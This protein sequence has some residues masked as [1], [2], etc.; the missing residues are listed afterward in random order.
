MLLQVHDG[1]A[2]DFAYPP[3]QVR[4]ARR[5]DVTLVLPDAL[6]DAVV[7]VGTGVRAWQAHEPGIL[8]DAKRDA[9]LLPELLELCHDAVGDVR[10][11][12]CIEAVH[13]AA[14]QIDLVLDAEVDE[15]GVHQNAVRRAQRGVVLEEKRRGRRL[16]AEG[17]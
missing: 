12:L 7:R 1:H 11:A 15:V 3:L 17:G 16:A 6:A 8:R 5:D 9:V 10:D 4:V 13:H 2:R 14:H